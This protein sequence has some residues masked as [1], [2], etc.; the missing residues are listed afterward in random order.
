MEVARI[1]PGLHYGVTVEV[2]EWTSP[3]ANPTAQK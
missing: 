2:R 1:H 3:A